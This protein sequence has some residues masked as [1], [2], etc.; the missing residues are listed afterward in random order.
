MEDAVS[1]E[2][3]THGYLAVETAS[4][5]ISC[6]VTDGWIGCE[7]PEKNWQCHEDGTPFHGVKCDANGSIEWSDGQ[8]GA[9]ARTKID[10]RVYHALGWTITAVEDD[11]LRFINEQTGH[12]M[13][14]TPDTVVEL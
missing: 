4:G 6:L 11:G 14:V 12:G 5:L 13:W 10:H 7:T 3:G 8:I 1:L 9:L 2:P